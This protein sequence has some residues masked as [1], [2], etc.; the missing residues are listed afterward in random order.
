M[1]DRWRPPRAIGEP[2]P[3][4]VRMRKDRHAGYVPAR[5]V[6]RLGML[7]GEIDGQAAE[8]EQVWT[9]GDLIT[10]AEYHQLVADLQRPAPF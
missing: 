4:F 2:R 9:S 7:V 6:R 5:I 10:E 1:V 3:C 8:V